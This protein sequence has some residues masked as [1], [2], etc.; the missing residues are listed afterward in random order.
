MQTNYLSFVDSTDSLLK[1]DAKK[2]FNLEV[3]MKLER[4]KATLARI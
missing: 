2:Q 4:A 3:R 1:L